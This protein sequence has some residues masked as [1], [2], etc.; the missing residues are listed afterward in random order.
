MTSQATSV[1]KLSTARQNSSLIKINLHLFN[2]GHGDTILVELPRNRWGLIDCCL[3]ERD[4]IRNRFFKFCDH[5]GIKTFDFIFQTHPDYDH[6][7]GMQSV[8]ERILARGERLGYYID[9]GLNALDA[10]HLMKNKPTGD[11]EYETLQ[12]KLADL[13]RAEQIN[14]QSLAA[15]SI[16]LYPSGLR[17]I[18]NFIPIGPDPRDRRR[19]ISDDLRKLATNASARPIA[20]E[21]SL[22]IVLT[23]KQDGQVFNMLLGAD[24]GN[25]GLERAIAYWKTYA[26]EDG[27]D[28]AFDVIKIPHHGSIKSHVNSV[29]L[30]KRPGSGPEAAIASAGTRRALPDREVL[31]DYM[32][33]GWNVYAT[34]TKRTP[35]SPSSLPLML[36]NRGASPGVEITSQTIHVS[37][38][39]SNGL[40]INPSSAKIMLEDLIHY[41]TAPVGSASKV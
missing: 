38:C 17:D 7:H 37:W 30:T 25:I 29:C 4:G 32:L 14:W 18:I 2:C 1:G 9:T 21:L 12:Q 5:L 36:A 22:V 11:N 34:T 13:D 33:N 40:T 39:K 10:K 15:R 23:V 6:Y 8:L 26:M 3:P 19:I 41:E 24:S 35:A 16:P 31:K 28:P 20:N 27:V